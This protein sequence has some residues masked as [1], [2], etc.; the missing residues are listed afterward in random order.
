MTDRHTPPLFAVVPAA[1][2][3]TRMAADLPKQYLTLEGRTLAEYTLARLLAFTPIEKVVVAVAPRDS[4][5]PQLPVAVHPR[6]LTVTGGDSRAQSVLSGVAAVLAESTEA[7]V[8]VHDMARPLVRLSDIHQL[9]AHRNAP[10][11]AILAQPVTDTVKQAGDHG[12]ID[13]TLDRERI[14]RALTPQ[15]FPALRLQQAL[16]AALQANPAAITD[17]ASAVEMAAG[18]PALVT[19][20]ADNI[21]IT[22]PEDLALA[23][24]YLRAQEKEGLAWP[25]V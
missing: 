23:R 12:T 20:H 8:L 15:L 18:R 3:G 17:E 11:G 4:W 22:I 9:L 21:K 5:W 13:R 1:G 6:V 24:F 10:D 25:F 19:G 14:W 7:Q 16:Q 2:I